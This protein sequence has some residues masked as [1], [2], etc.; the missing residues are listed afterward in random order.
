MLFRQRRFCELSLSRFRDVWLNLIAQ[1]GIFRL[2]LFDSI[3]EGGNRSG[4]SFAPAADCSKP[5]TNDCTSFHGGMPPPDV[6]RGTQA[7][8]P[9]FDLIV[10]NLP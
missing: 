1:S 6:F 9:R 8:R 4:R 3:F 5:L 7:A 10:V 2:E